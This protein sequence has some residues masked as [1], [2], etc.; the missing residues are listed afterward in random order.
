MTLADKMIGPIWIIWV[1]FAIFVILTVVF[2]LGQGSGLV[3]GYN[4]ASK[5]EQEKYDKKKLCKVV[6]CGMA[7][8]SIMLFVMAV[9]INVLPVDFIYFFVMIC[10]V[11]CIAIIVLSNTICKK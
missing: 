11:D 3:A 9:W 1:V 7:V 6:G 5:E 8:I 2:L 4:T 10:I